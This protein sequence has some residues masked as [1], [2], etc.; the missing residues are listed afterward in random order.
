MILTYL[1]S[2]H[3]AEMAA[4]PLYGIMPEHQRHP[5]AERNAPHER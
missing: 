2:V 4:T 5:L 1:I 3:P